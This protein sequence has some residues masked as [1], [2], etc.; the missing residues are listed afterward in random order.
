LVPFPVLVMKDLLHGPSE[1]MYISKV[2][3]TASS[4]IAYAEQSIE[5]MFIIESFLRWLGKV[6]LK[7]DLGEAAFNHALQR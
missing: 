7:A 4:D 5:A 6:T 3:E 1:Q 2:R